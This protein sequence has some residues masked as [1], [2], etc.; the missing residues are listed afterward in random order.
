MLVEYSPF[1]C[2]RPLC[3]SPDLAFNNIGTQC[4]YNV[5]LKRIR[6]TVSQWKSHNALCACVVE[7]Q[8]AASA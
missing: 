7:S 8:R 2:Q 1:K 4:T 6:V 3:V 5:T